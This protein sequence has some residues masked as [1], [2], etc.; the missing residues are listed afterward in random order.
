[1]GQKIHPVAVRLRQ[2]RHFDASWYDDQYQSSLKNQIASKKILESFFRMVAQYI[3]EFFLGR[4]FYQQSHQKTI[5]TLFLFHQRGKRD[6]RRETKRFKYS[7]KNKLD[8]ALTKNNHAF[9]G[10]SAFFTKEIPLK[11]RPQNVEASPT[12]YMSSSSLASPAFLSVNSQALS[13]KSIIEPSEVPNTKWKLTKKLV[14]I[15]SKRYLLETNLTDWVFLGKK[16]HNRSRGQSNVSI[17]EKPELLSQEYRRS[18]N[19][20]ATW[21]WDLDLNS[22]KHSSRASGKI[23][24]KLIEKMIYATFLRHRVKQNVAKL[25]QIQ[26]LNMILSGSGRSWQCSQALRNM[27]AVQSSFVESSA[28]PFL[29]KEAGR[30]QNNGLQKESVLLKKHPK[31]FLE[32]NQRIH[33]F[34]S[35]LENRLCSFFQKNI[36]IRPV[37]CK[38]LKFSAVFLAE[39]IAQILTQKKHQKK[40]KMPYR[41]IKKLIKTR[42]KSIGIRI[43]CSGRLGGVEMARKFVLKQ[44]QTSLNVFSQKID[45]AQRTA[46]TRYGIIGIKVWMSFL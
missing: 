27:E 8:S 16:P 43:Q 26:A 7:T 40:K 13:K 44:G 5:I 25:H 28:S 36:Y 18:E 2:N 1:M 31:A 45:F 9:L 4:I 46:L 14:S 21:N 37:I 20:Q 38:H 23:C 10:K 19:S 33:P 11:K 12:L 34:I 41:Q 42:S 3:P 29:S 22:T 39:E 17:V 24:Q 15:F 6:S 32:E 30:M 35:H